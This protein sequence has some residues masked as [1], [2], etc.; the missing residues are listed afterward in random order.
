M[1]KPTSKADCNNCIW[2][3]RDG[4][5][6]SWECEPVDKREAY[7]AWIEKKERESE[8]TGDHR[9]TAADGATV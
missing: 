7:K 8:Q 2:S 5:C 4:S 3:S 1:D 6:S 9:T